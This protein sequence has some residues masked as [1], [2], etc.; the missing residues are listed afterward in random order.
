MRIGR[1]LGRGLRGVALLSMLALFSSAAAAS[2]AQSYQLAAASAVAKLDFE[3]ALQIYTQGLEQP[4]DDKERA[5]LLLMRGITA[6]LAKKEDLAENDFNAVVKM[7]GSTDSRAYRERGFLYHHQGRY[8]LALAD[9]T[10]GAKLFPDNAIFPDGQGRALMEQGKFDEAINRFDEAIRLDPTSGLY[11]LNRA[12]AYNRSD[13]PQA[14]LEG[15]DRALALGKLTRSDAYRLLVGA[16]SA[17][18]KL[19]NA[20]AAIE[21]LDKAVELNP[22]S[23]TALRYRGLAHEQAGQLDRARRDYEAILTLQ[24]GDKFAAARLQGLGAK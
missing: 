1:T 22:K 20:T 11:M 21:S 18:I 13:R 10:T 14:A 12:E 9:Y 4:F 6:D 8:E 16:G 3:R 23:A 5:H 17:H 15:Y 19:K 24:P 2:D 7:V